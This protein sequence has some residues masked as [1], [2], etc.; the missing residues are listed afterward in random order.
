MAF[1][2][3]SVLTGLQCIRNA[4]ENNNQITNPKNFEV[5]S[6]TENCHVKRTAFG[7]FLTVRLIE[8]VRLIEVCKNCV[9][10]VV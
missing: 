8:G 5:Q 9:M 3:V 6:Q 7:T 4:A 2:L 1:S 10:F